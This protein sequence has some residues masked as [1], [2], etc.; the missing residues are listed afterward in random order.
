METSILTFRLIKSEVEKYKL[1]NNIENDS[2]AFLEFAIEKVLDINR[3]EILESVID[4][5]ND[6]GIDAIYV[7]E[8]SEERP[9]VY[10]FQSK[11]YQSEERFGRSFEGDALN[12][13]QHAIDN[14]ILKTPESIHD[15]NEFLLSKL[16]DIKAL[17]NPRFQIIFCS[18]S[19][20]ADSRVKKQF[21]EYI[22]G[23]SQGLDFFRFDF[24]T[25]AKLSELVTPVTSK[26]IN[27]TLK[28]SGQYFDWSL[29]EARV[30]VGRI[31]GKEIAELCKKEGKEL[32][33]RNVRG[34]FGRKK[35]IVNKGIYKTATDPI[36]GSR[37]FFLNNGITIV[38]NSVSYLAVR[39]NPEIEITNLQ[40]VNGGQTT[41][42][43]Y[44]AYQAGVLDESVYV[45][46]KIV[47]TEKKELVEKIAESTN[48]QTNVNA[49]DLRSNDQIQKTI[50]RMLFNEG[51]YYET[52]K[53]KFRE[54]PSAK[55][56]R[57][58]M[59]VA[60]QAFYAFNFKKPADA[61][62]KKRQLFGTLYEEIFSDEDKKIAE[63]ILTSYLTLDWVRKLHPKYRDKYTFVKY[64]EFHSLALLS[65][66]E[67][68]TA[69]DLEKEET[70]NLYELI[71]K[72][73]AEIVDE[74]I[75]KLG[76]RYS[77]RMLFIDPATYGRISEAIVDIRNNT[78]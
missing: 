64:A 13:M 45:L 6:R 37:F 2:R 68:K 47:A 15:A 76:D 49:R 52:R 38:C 71:L 4:G 20:E 28:L 36:E 50:E 66:L 78:K 9:V 27:E 55:G 34:Y 54:Q 74:E 48:T 56:K 5:S 25:L 59:E 1:E 75:K 40:I 63:N 42:S 31:S 33:E 24:L 8:D 26:K 46:L 18:N 14:L 30:I 19:S 77:H 35:N 67:I 17:S 41:N 73:T 72:A 60:T 51:Y 65:L 29:G 10:L 57:I 62:N 22:K 53:G 23:I 7:D 3:D 44:E 43:I 16:K 70:Q 21:D 11:Y 58:D 12:K 61:K 32:F 39:E 69:A